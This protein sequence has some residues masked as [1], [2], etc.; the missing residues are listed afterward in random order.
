MPRP[1]SNVWIHSLARAA[2]WRSA[3]PIGLAVGLA[4]VVVNQ[5]DHWWR[6]EITTGVI[7]KTILAPLLSLSVAVLSAANHHARTL[8]SSHE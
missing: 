2:V 7:L 1:A 3:L 5:G 4:Q 8:S 6:G